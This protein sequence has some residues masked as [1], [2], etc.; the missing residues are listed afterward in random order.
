[1][2]YIAPPKRAIAVLACFALTLLFGKSTQ[3]QTDRL[4]VTPPAPR[5]G[6]AQP[7]IPLDLL[8]ATPKL[9]YYDFDAPGENFDAAK[10]TDFHATAYSLKGRTAT[11]VEPRQGVIAAD[12][13]VLPLGSVVNVR[14]GQYSGVYIVHDT[15][16]RIIG[17][18]VDVW[19]PTSNEARFF[20]RRKVKLQVL[21][22]GPKPKTKS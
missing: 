20:G 9:K 1:M 12:P 19:V 10:S 13:R 4:T 16:K 7:E 17:N 11:G 15:G 6:P 21:R 22:Y 5:I 3:A 14:A 2:N 18:V 8:R